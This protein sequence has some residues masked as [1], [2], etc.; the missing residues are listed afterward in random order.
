MALLPCGFKWPLSSRNSDVSAEEVP[1]R[2][3]PIVGPDTDDQKAYTMLLLFTTLTNVGAHD[4]IASYALFS[5]L[6]CRFLDANPDEHLAQ[7]LVLGMMSPSVANATYG[8]ED[9]PYHLQIL[10]KLDMPRI[11]KTTVRC[12]S[13]PFSCAT[14]VMNGTVLIA[15]ATLA[16]RTA[17]A[18]V[19]EALN[20]LIA[21]LQSNNWSIR[22]VCLRALDRFH[23][24][25]SEAEA[26]Q[27]DQQ[28]LLFALASGS[29]P[30]EL[31][32]AQQAFG[33]ERCASATYISYVQSI[34]RAMRQYV[35]DHDLRSLGLKLYDLSLS[36]GAMIEDGQLS[37]YDETTRRFA[38]YTVPGMPFYQYKDAFAACT[39][40]IREAGVPG[41]KDI[42]NVLSIQAEMINDRGYPALNL[43]KKYIANG[44]RH[45]FHYLVLTLNGAE[46]NEKIIQAA[47]KGMKC[48]EGLT[49]YVKLRL[50]E[51]SVHHS[52]Q[53]GL[54]KLQ[55]ARVEK[56]EELF[57][58]GSAILMSAY[59]DAQQYLDEAPPDDLSL[60]AVTYWYILLRILL[61]E[62]PI[63]SFP[64]DIKVCS[65]SDSAFE[66]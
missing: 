39:K 16:A 41:E 32:D 9:T 25:D 14:C 37:T 66:D 18:E 59:E 60:K 48:T 53:L 50:L 26:T 42:A 2:I 49:I 36:S 17:F 7:H 11:L 65:S 28:R 57:Q 22:A 56:S 31:R 19:P 54:D 3:L 47:K 52:S 64:D 40:A 5:D 58:L 8:I 12:I 38:P 4:S 46:T 63:I 51:R 61:T 1:E 62:D 29:M 21:G 10:K 27:V 43:A 44:S 23:A 6:L 15:S 30:Q 13:K 45:A 35:S 24:L 20:I 34:E 33:F 55:E